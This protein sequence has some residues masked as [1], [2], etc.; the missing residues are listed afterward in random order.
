MYFR[1]CGSCKSKKNNWVRKSQIRKLQIMYGPQILKIKS[2]HL[3][4]THLWYFLIIATA[5][6]VRGREKNRSRRTNKSRKL[7]NVFFLFLY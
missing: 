4:T 3:R 7:I 1:I 2:A 6:Q 5:K